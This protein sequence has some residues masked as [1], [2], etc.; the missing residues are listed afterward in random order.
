MLKNTKRTQRY[1]KLSESIATRLCLTVIKQ[2]IQ[3]FI[4]IFF[5]LKKN[6]M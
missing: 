3:Y 1:N 4:A 2:K 6:F 5:D